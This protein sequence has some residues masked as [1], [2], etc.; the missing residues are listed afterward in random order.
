MAQR[1]NA[2]RVRALD[3]TQCAEAEA[4]CEGSWL[5]CLTLA[6][7]LLERVPSKRAVLAG[8]SGRIACMDDLSRQLIVPAM[9]QGSAPVRYS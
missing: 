7:A 2:Q 6:A 1:N 9:Q 5:H 4:G 8:V 3:T